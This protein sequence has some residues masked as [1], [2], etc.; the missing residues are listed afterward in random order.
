[1]AYRKTYVKRRAFRRRPSRLPRRR[2]VVKRRSRIPRRR[3]QSKR[4]LLNLTSTK[5]RDNVSPAFYRVGDG[6][7]ATPVLNAI[8]LTATTPAFSTAHAIIWSPTTRE[9]ASPGNASDHARRSQ[10]PFYRGLSER[11]RIKTSNS[12]PW[13]WR[14]ILFAMKGDLDPSVAFHLKTGNRYLR[15]MALLSDGSITGNTAQGL[16]NNQIFNGTPGN[17]WND[18]MLA[19]TDTNTVTIMY[20]KTVQLKSGNDTG[21][22]RDVKLWHPMNKTLY[23]EYDEN[24]SF[25]VSF[26]TAAPGKRGM[27]DVYV[28]DLFQPHTFDEDGGSLE[29]NPNATIY[30]HEK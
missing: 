2:Y 6:I 1:M 11:I 16:I 25:D 23:Y 15:G 27:G 3:M 21:I 20:D 14:R 18:V 24:G 5:K 28:Y 8:A 12:S 30:W 7:T 29:F 19:K 13:L 17:D 22:I 9:Y 10:S 4:S 26:M